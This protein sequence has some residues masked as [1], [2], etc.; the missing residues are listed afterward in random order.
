MDD[1]LRSRRGRSARPTR[2]RRW[3]AGVRG[4]AGADDVD[5]LALIIEI[6][7]ETGARANL[8]RIAVAGGGDGCG[9]VRAYAGVGGAGGVRGTPSHDI[10][11]GRFADRRTER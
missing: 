1:R 3:A 10:P 8:H 11:R 9:D 5:G 4:C 2:R 6:D 7:P